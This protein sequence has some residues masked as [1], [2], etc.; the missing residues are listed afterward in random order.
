MEARSLYRQGGVHPSAINERQFLQGGLPALPKIGAAPQYSPF[1]SP[2]SLISALVPCCCPSLFSFS[3]VTQHIATS[4]PQK[5]AFPSFRNGHSFDSSPHDDAHLSFR[6]SSHSTVICDHVPTTTTSRRRRLLETPTLRKCRTLH[7]CTRA[8]RTQD[9]A[10]RQSL[11]RIFTSSRRAINQSFTTCAHLCVTYPASTIHLRDDDSLD[12]PGRRSPCLFHSPFK[13]VLRHLPRVGQ[14]N[15]LSGAPQT[16]TFQF[17]SP[18]EVK[19]L[20]QA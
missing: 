1:P 14:R 2:S 5:T 12:D 13:R 8:Y 15:P 9:N 7:S 20:G 3:I 18:K 11:A 4:S 16:P 17:S 6:A 19:N 10:V